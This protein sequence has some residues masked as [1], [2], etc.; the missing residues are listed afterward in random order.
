MTRTAARS[1][2]FTGRWTRFNLSGCFGVVKRG[3]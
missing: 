2:T 3:A 1:F